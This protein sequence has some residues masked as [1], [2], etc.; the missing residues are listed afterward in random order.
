VRFESTFRETCL[1]GSTTAPS[2]S[3][4]ASIARGR[5]HVLPPFG[6]VRS[7]RYPSLTKTEYARASSSG[8]A[9][10][11]PSASEN[12][13]CIGLVTPMRRVVR[14]TSSMPTSAASCA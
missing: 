10:C 6:P 4:T 1:N 5:F 7:M 13:C 11:V 12:T 9:A 2:T 8:F 14:I 3:R